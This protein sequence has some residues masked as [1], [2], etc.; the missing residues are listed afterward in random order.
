MSTGHITAKLD[1]SNRHPP[2]PHHPAIYLFKDP[3]PNNSGWMEIYTKIV[4]FFNERWW[5]C[6]KISAVSAAK[7]YSIKN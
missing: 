2:H 6:Y 5:Y 3:P 1:F 4:E 7:K